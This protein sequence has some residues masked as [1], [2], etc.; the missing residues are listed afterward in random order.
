MDNTTDG[1]WDSLPVRL[2]EGILQTLEEMKFT[3][4]T[5]VQVILIN[6]PLFNNT[7]Q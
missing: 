4:M 6:L 7:E 5:P 1:T 3:H 2:N